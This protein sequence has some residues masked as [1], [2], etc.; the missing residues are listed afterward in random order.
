M[1]E[2]K[3]C[4]VIVSW[5][6]DED[7]LKK[8]IRS[9][10]PQVDSILIVDNGSN[11]Y[12][13]LVSIILESTKSN[14]L[15]LNE[16]RGIGIAL[17][18][19]ISSINLNDF[20]WILTL[21]QDSV[22][23]HN[24]VSQIFEEFSTL[25]VEQKMSCG[26]L[27]LRSEHQQINNYFVR[28]N[29]KLSVIGNQRTFQTMKHVITSGSLVRSEIFSK[30]KFNEKYFIDQ[31]DFDFCISVR[32]FNYGIL[33]QNRISLDHLLGSQA[34]WNNLQYSY[35]A[36]ERLYYIIRNSTNLL[37]RGR[38]SL[39]YYVNQLIVW[40]GSFLLTNG[41]KS[42]IRVIRILFFGMLDGIFFR[43]GKN[44]HKLSK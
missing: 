43:L 41:P 38:Q 8:S 35:H 25:P 40:I 7:R 9:L 23:Q 19:A 39:H 26:V 2:A 37:I 13:S 15:Q 14:I 30:V 33:R 29:E 21:D 31:V 27:S 36:D 18:E 24:A 17:N 34:Q 44:T 20:D 5:N 22:L 28:S 1:S 16:N 32:R 10:E 12:D 42:L 6:P 11:N 3:V 4:A